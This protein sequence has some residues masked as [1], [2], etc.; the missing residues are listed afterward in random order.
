MIHL[1]LSLC[2]IKSIPEERD[3]LQ[4]K[5]KN[6]HNAALYCLFNIYHFLVIPPSATRFMPVIKSFSVA[7]R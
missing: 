4:K 5:Y 7:V 6:L 1:P 2:S 3:Y